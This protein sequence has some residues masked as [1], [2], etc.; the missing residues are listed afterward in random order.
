MDKI[1]LI[2][3][4]CAEVSVESVAVL[5]FS[6]II[7]S[8]KSRKVIKFPSMNKKLFVV[9]SVFLGMT[10]KIMA[11][12]PPCPI[13]PPDSPQMDLDGAP[14]YITLIAGLLLGFAFFAGK[15]LKK[16]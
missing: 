3:K 8:R 5:K 16:A 15:K 2:L 9:L 10:G 11:Q 4:K 12:Q 14:L 6:C 13:C 1:I 7:V